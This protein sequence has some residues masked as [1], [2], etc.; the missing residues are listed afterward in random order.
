[1]LQHHAPQASRPQNHTRQ[2][3]TTPDH[4]TRAYSGWATRTA[5]RGTDAASSVVTSPFA[6]CRPKMMGGKCGL[7]D[8]SRSGRPREMHLSARPREPPACGARDGQHRT[9]TKR[10]RIAICAESDGAAP[11]IAPGN[12]RARNENRARW[13][14][15]PGDIVGPDG[16][17]CRAIPPRAR[18]KAE[19]DPVHS[20]PLHRHRHPYI[21]IDIA[22]VL[23][24]VRMGITGLRGLPESSVPS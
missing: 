4:T 21:A 11:A 16:Q 2:H 12:V 5:W 19:R 18:S 15:R 24:I 1:M 8:W 23:T 17:R 10:D 7:P 3:E 9:S 14:R 20:T 6:N 13:T 22:T